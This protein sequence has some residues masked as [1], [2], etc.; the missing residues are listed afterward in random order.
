MPCELS[1]RITPG[2]A[3]CLIHRRDYSASCRTCTDYFMEPIDMS[4]KK[5][6]YADEPAPV[7]APLRKGDKFTCP[8]CG[9][10]KSY[11]SKGLCAQCN[12]AAKKLQ[13]AEVQPPADVQPV[14]LIPRATELFVDLDAFGKVEN[15]AGDMEPFGATDPLLVELIDRMMLSVER[16]LLEDV[17]GMPFDV[18]AIHIVKAVENM[19]RRVA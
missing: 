9:K 19:A 11:E 16:R 13:E 1:A 8:C 2:G 4:K 17:S 15:A 5:P 3:K 7:P 10:L 6:V 12:K 18:A 14:T